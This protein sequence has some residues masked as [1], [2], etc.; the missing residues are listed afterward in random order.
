VCSGAYAFTHLRVAKVGLSWRVKGCASTTNVSNNAVIV[1][2]Q[3]VAGTVYTRKLDLKDAPPDNS[4]QLTKWAAKQLE[5]DPTTVRSAKH[6]FDII[7]FLEP[8]WLEAKQAADLAVVELLRQED[9]PIRDGKFGLLD[10]TKVTDKLK[11]VFPHLPKHAVDAMM[12]RIMIEYRKH[13]YDVLGRGDHNTL[14]HKY[15]YPILIRKGKWSPRP[16]TNDMPAPRIEIILG[17]EEGTVLKGKNSNQ[18]LTLE[19]CGGAGYA[20]FVTSFKKLLTGEAVGGELALKGVK[21]AGLPRSAT[22]LHAN[23]RLELPTPAAEESHGTLYVATDDKSFLYA[24]V[25][26]RK[27]WRFNGDQLPKEFRALE[28]KPKKSPRLD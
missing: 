14:T 13:R 15:G 1:E 22:E 3:S 4:P 8:F 28:W 5:V 16:L 11:A 2:L 23:L 6:G 19:L 26:D 17:K 12:L 20:R 9:L 10:Q 27:L 24:R 18:R 25:K 21:P 7:R